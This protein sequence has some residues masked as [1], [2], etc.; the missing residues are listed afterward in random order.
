VFTTK[1][2]AKS[3]LASLGITA[4]AGLLAAAAGFGQGDEQ[5]EAVAAPSQN[6]IEA[7]S[8][9]HGSI[10][11]IPGIEGIDAV[12]LKNLEV[13]LRVERRP[14]EPPPPHSTRAA[15]ALSTLPPT[16]EE[17]PEEV[18]DQREELQLEMEGS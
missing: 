10:Q 16:Q 13:V 8:D 12:A 2:L 6:T 4:A 15:A 1:F 11:S 14:P 5:K 7:I 9:V 3:L 17:P 18:P